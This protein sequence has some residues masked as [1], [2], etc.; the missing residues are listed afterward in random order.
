MVARQSISISQ[1]MSWWSGSIMD[2][3]FTPNVYSVNGRY[4]FEGTTTF[5]EVDYITQLMSDAN[6][7]LYSCKIKQGDNLYFDFVPCYRKSDNEIWLYDRVGKQFYTNAW[8]GTFI[9]WPD[10]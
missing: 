4:L 10:V 5:N 7:R 3:E 1:D 2:W 9:K 6:L 8:T